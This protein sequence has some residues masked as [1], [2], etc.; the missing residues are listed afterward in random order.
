MSKLAEY[1]KGKGEEE[2]ALAAGRSAMK[3]EWL[4]ELDKL[5]TSIDEWLQ[6]SVDIGLDLA[7]DTV[8]ISEEKLGSYAAPRRII[9]FAGSRVDIEPL[10]RV[11]VGGHGRVDVRSALRTVFLIFSKPEGIWHI[12]EERDRTSRQP[13]NKD[14]F[15]RLME[16]FL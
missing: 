3:E 10:A 9:K 15:E 14:S 5:M 16:T 12:V 8:T 4:R 2:N 11:I 7:K 1:L 13:L 6:P